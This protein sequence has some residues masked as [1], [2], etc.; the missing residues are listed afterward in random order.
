MV[1]Y[2]KERDVLVQVGDLIDRG[3]DPKGAVALAMENEALLVLG[4]HEEKMLRWRRNEGRRQKDPSRKN[5]MQRPPE[6][7]ISEWA[8]LSEEETAYLRA[9]PPLR[10]IADGWIAVHAGIEPKFSLGEQKEDR[11]VR[12]RYVS[13]DGEMVGYKHG[14]LD[15]PAGT[16][17]WMEKYEGK[18]NVVYGHA[19]HSLTNPREDIVAKTNARCVGIDTGCCYGG[20]LT[21]MV[22]TTAGYEFAK[23]K[24]RMELLPEASGCDFLVAARLSVAA[25]SLGLFVPV[26]RF[27]ASG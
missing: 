12:V 6:K 13:N 17:P 24:A 8:S 15:Q 4:N 14:N 19:V 25:T 20:H 9:A 18:E 1:D 16:V 11:L 7:R 21:A 3:P 23:V 2:K 26:K 27:F 22:L 5:M 10:L